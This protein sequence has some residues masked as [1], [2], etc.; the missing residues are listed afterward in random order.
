MKHI[1]DPVINATHANVIQLSV[2]HRHDLINE[3]CVNREAKVFNNNLR[4]RLKHFNNVKMIEVSSDREMYTKH[5][6]NI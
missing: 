3:S 2:P 6:D 5:M 1:L 4:N